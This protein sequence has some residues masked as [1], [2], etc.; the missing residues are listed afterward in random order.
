M[1][2]YIAHLIQILLFFT[3]TYIIMVVMG[4]LRKRSIT[5]KRR[6]LN[7]LS[8]ST[9]KPQRIAV[10]SQEFQGSESK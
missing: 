4:R 2:R 9:V 6:K 8:R 10:K 7:K 3:G 1:K 5:A